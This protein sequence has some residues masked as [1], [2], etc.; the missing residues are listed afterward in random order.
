ME[1]DADAQRTEL[2]Y[3]NEP[4]QV[5]PRNIG[6]AISLSYTGYDWEPGLVTITDG[7]KTY[8]T[9][10]NLS[11]SESSFNS[12]R[13]LNPEV[14]DM[15]N[16]VDAGAL[17]SAQITSEIRTSGFGKE[18][19]HWFMLAGFLLLITESLVSIFYKAETVT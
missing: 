2:I 19:W 17:T 1:R 6:G 9:A 10:V 14:S 3:N 7:E 11:K 16:I 12:E 8:K 4:I 15:I 13:G 18:I 5:N